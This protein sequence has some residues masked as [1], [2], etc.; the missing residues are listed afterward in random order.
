MDVAE[1]VVEAFWYVEA[2]AMLEVAAGMLVEAAVLITVAQVE[3]KS[4][5]ET[6]YAGAVAVALET[7]CE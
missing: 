2:I 6:L 5:L 4:L 1:T 7:T 3:V